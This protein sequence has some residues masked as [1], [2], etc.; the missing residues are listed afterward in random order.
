MQTVS[1]HQSVGEC[2]ICLPT[3]VQFFV[4]LFQG[5]PRHGDHN[6]ILVSLQACR[7]I[8]SNNSADFIYTFCLYA[9]EH[10]HFPTKGGCAWPSLDYA[11]ASTVVELSAPTLVEG[12]G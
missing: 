3:K 7:S 4:V 8:H 2:A 6:F 9:T 10:D 1:Q 5:T 11:L 12:G